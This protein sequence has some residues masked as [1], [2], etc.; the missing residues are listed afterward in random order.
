M[1]RCVKEMNALYASTPAFWQQDDSW[2]G[3]EWLNADDNERSIVTFLRRDKDGNVIVCMTNFTPETYDDYRMPLPA[4]G[5]LHEILN[6]DGTIYGGS[7]K[8][9][10][11]AI[12]GQRKPLGKFAWSAQVVVPPLSTV[13]FTFTQ[14]KRKKLNAIP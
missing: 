1:Q 6:T 4:Y 2:A 14:P 3:F 9:N 12:R 8:G 13:F 11:H 5:Y 7:G 10:P